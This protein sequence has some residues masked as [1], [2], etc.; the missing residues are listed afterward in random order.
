MT[1]FSDFFAHEWAAAGSPDEP[2]V[3]GGIT[4]WSYSRV[5]KWQECPRAAYY[6]Y[7]ERRGTGKPNDAMLRGTTAH[8]EAA[9]IYKGEIYKTDTPVLTAA[10]RGVLAAQREAWAGDLE[11][12]L[13]VAWTPAWEPRPWF[14]KSVAFRCAFDGFAYSAGTKTIL[15]YE[16]KTGRPRE[17]YMDQAELYACVA[18]KMQPEIEKVIVNIQYLDLPVTRAPVIYEWDAAW[19]TTG[20]RG[21]P[22][23]NKWVGLANTMLADR[24]YPMRAGPQCK[25]C[26]HRGE[27]G[28]P[29]AIF[30]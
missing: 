29:C 14:D 25:Y 4:A 6:S 17:S 1:K 16:H 19:L 11:A 3:S 15:I 27:V 20:F 22:L 21:G 24:D 5:A 30:S 28:G 13:Q 23:F 18:H 7:V 26:N 8:N 10:W 12:E 2:P 9:A